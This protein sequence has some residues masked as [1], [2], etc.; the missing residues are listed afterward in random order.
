MEK[1]HPQHFGNMRTPAFQRCFSVNGPREEMWLKH[2]NVNQEMWP[3]SSPQNYGPMEPEAQVWNHMCCLENFGTSPESNGCMVCHS[4]SFP[5]WWGKRME[6]VPCGPSK[7]LMMGRMEKVDSVR[8]WPFFGILI[9]G[10]YIKVTCQ[11][12][13]SCVCVF[14]LAAEIYIIFRDSQFIFPKE[15]VCCWVGFELKI[16]FSMPLWGISSLLQTTRCMVTCG[17]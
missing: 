10:V 6:K 4:Q 14:F 8:I 7:R 15:A 11:S 5:Q 16:D 3:G 1:K 12:W 9:S 13:R 2:V 17:S